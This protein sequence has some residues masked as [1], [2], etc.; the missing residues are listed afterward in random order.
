MGTGF[1]TSQ[2]KQYRIS[3]DHG[4]PGGDVSHKTSCVVTTENQSVTPNQPLSH[5]KGTI[6]GAHF[7]SSLLMGFVLNTYITGVPGSS[8]V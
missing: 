3:G 7:K 2:A 1:E 5:A 4:N 8:V 6:T